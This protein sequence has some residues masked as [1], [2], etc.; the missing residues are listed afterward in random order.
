MIH[1]L[2]IKF[3]PNLIIF[4]SLFPKGNG[5]SG[6][7]VIIAQHLYRQNRGMYFI[8]AVQHPHQVGLILQMA[9]QARYWRRTF[10]INRR[11]LHTGK[12]I[13]PAFVQWCL[14]SLR[15]IPMK[16]Q[17]EQVADSLRRDTAIHLCDGEP[18]QSDLVLLAATKRLY[19]FRKNLGSN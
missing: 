8:K 14:R 18:F 11:D 13:G 17:S 1:S 15:R 16:F 4:R 9:D 5:L 10:R 12:S 7:S 2:W 3:Y 6:P 19:E